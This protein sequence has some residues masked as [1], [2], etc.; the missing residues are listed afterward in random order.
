MNLHN[1]LHELIKL[2]S[3]TEKIVINEYEDGGG[4]IH[5]GLD[6]SKFIVAAISAIS[7]SLQEI[8]PKVKQL[9]WINHLDA[10]GGVV[11]YAHGYMDSKNDIDIV[12]EIHKHT[13]QSTMQ[14]YS[15][16]TPT[17]DDH[18]AYATL[19]EAK[20]AAQSHFEA[21]ILGCLED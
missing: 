14:G 19:E 7:N 5:A 9:R 15:V 1:K 12:Y 8:K 21:L 3:N 4:Y 11:V 17:D 6:N 18:N 20:A 10:L 13:D 16:S 2:S